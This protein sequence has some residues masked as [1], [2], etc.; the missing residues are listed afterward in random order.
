MS[1]LVFLIFAILIA[2]AA[3]F[4][5]WPVLRAKKPGRLVLSAAL[6]VAVLAIGGGAYVMLG[7][8]WLAARTFQAPAPDDLPA[9]VASLAAHMRE[10]PGDVRGLTLLGRAYLS[11]GR[12]GDAAQA[13]GQA[14]SASPPDTPADKRGE[15]YSAYGEALTQD[16]GGTVNADAEKAFERALKANPKDQAARFYMGQAYVA[17]G[18]K[19]KALAIWEGL[20]ADAPAKAPWRDALVDR[21]ARLKAGDGTAAPDIGAMVAGLAAR[22]KENPN[23]PQ[24]WPRLV[25]AYAVLGETD[26]ARAALADGRKALKDQPEALARLNE[27]ASGLKQLQPAKP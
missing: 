1:A 20:L 18:E 17:R 22:L 25:R 6:A 15:L 27:E 9:M 24:G 7:S 8:P 14:L 12:P 23:D 26:K 4:V 2:V 10:Q 19:Q 3:G 5:C 11:L 21:V 13:F 16:A